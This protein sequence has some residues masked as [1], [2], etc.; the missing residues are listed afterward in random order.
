MSD[1]CKSRYEPLWI[2]G[3]TSVATQLQPYEGA[4]TSQSSYSSTSS[5]QPI[6]RQ[7]KAAP[8]SLIDHLFPP[9]RHLVHGST[10][11]VTCVA[12]SSLSSANFFR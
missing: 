11:Q 3:N 6:N 2:R 5:T 8:G 1:A 10:R 12:Y 7:E 9:L 4:G